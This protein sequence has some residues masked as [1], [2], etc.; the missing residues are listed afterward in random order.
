MAIDK[1]KKKAAIKKTRALLKMEADTKAGNSPMQKARRAQ[2][3]KRKKQAHD[4][5]EKPDHYQFTVRAI[6]GH[7]TAVDVASVIEGLFIHDAHLAQ[8]FKY[9]GR[10]GRKLGQPYT[11]DVAKARYW[12]TRALKFHG[13]KDD[14]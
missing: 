1:V 8:A 12:L 13:V 6:D 11:K 14:G 4:D 9:M 7:E 3:A 5:V 2:A 10:A